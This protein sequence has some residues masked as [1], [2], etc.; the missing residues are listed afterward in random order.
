MIARR[1]GWAVSAAFV[2][3]LLFVLGTGPCWAESSV[4]P[5][6]NR[7][8]QS[9]DPE[10]WKA[11]FERP[12][13]EI[14][15]RRYDIL[16]ALH[17]KKGQVV[18][19]VGTGTGFFA[20]MMAEQ[21]GPEGRVYGVDIAPGFVDALAQRAEEQGFHNVTGIVNDARSVRLP[22]ASVDLVYLGD[23]YH[24]FEY[25]ES[26]L[27][28]IRQALKPTGELV[29]V[30]FRKISGQSGSWVMNHVRANEQEVIREIEA[31]GF[32]LVERSD[33]MRTQYFLRFRRL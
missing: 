12:G 28:S 11:V 17:V 18:A 23:T 16:D 22:A 30:D 13:R 33:L 15:D 5:G 21:V 2:A 20:V 25:P 31:A 26:M 6:I 4:N 9:P 8:Y 27:A 24:H 29:I 14:W 3:A 1:H 19:D 7:H 32:E 10:R